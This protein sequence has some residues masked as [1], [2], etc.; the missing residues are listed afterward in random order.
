[1]YNADSTKI[2]DNFWLHRI[3]CTPFSLLLVTSYINCK[4]SRMVSIHQTKTHK[5]D[6]Y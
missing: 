3:E 4:G 5:Q 6:L 2:A 1:M